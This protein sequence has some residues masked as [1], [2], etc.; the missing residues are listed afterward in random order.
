VELTDY[1]IVENNRI[2]KDVLRLRLR[3]VAQ[4]EPPRPGQFV[5]LKIDGCYLR[6]PISVCDWDDC[7][8]LTLLY[9]VV[10]EGTAKLARHLPGE[11]LNILTGLGN[12]Y[13]ICA[14]AKR[15]VLLGG[16]VG[17]PPLYGLA[18]ALVR[19]GQRPLAILGFNTAEEVFY[20]N[21]FAA[22]CETKITTA[23]GSL[24]QKGFVTHALKA[25]EDYDAL[26]ACGPEAMLRA[27]YHQMPPLA[28]GQAQFSFERRMGCGFGAC[29]VCSCRTV[30]GYKRI[31]MDG[32]VLTREEI[33][34]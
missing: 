28:A 19:A 18:K 21:E 2:A 24:G 7:G 11:S 3:C 17:A 1:T 8:G 26:Y 16:G 34:W 13:T 4:R 5:N 15:P 10:G 27:V 23:D 12:G 9:K 30:A 20:R 33:V 6:R 32:P 14:Q 29:M 25:A 22:L 31:C